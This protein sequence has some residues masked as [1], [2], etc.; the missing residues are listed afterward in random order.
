MQTRFL[1]VALAVLGL[2]ADLSAQQVVG[3][4]FCVLR[5]QSLQIGDANQNATVTTPSAATAG[6]DV[7]F[8]FRAD[9]DAAAADS[10]FSIGDSA[11]SSLMSLDGGGNLSVDGNVT[12]AGM[13]LG[14][15][16]GVKLA[17]SVTLTEA[18]GAEE[19]IRVTTATTESFGLD[20]FYQVRA[21]DATPDYAVRAGSLKL[22]C[23]NNA[24]VVT[25]T[26]SATA[27]T[28]DGSV[29]INTN[30]KTLTYAIAVDVGTAN[31]AFIT[32]N[33]DSDMTVTSATI[34]WTA[35]LNG[36]GTIS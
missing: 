32:F 6:V 13:V 1:A 10:L 20:L 25:C 18:G 35:I 34:T 3:C 26:K 11:D 12:P 33:I 16:G 17:K 7:F 4:S 24:T 8:S 30:A 19:V 2:A 27:Q 23:V 5:G 28:D 36:S 22:V 9:A 29:I 21:K 31:V 14:T 15:L